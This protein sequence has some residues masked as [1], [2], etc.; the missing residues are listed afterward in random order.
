MLDSLTWITGGLG[1]AFAVAGASYYAWVFGLGSKLDGMK[2]I[3]MNGMMAQLRGRH[4]ERDPASDVQQA[5]N[6]ALNGVPDLGE[7]PDDGLWIPE[8]RQPVQP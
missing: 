6:D 4:S 7:E 2:R 3:R 1:L 8:V 5:L